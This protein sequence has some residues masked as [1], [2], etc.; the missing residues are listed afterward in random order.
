MEIL[1][2]FLEDLKR[3]GEKQLKIQASNIL[4]IIK[5]QQQN[6]AYQPKKIKLNNIEYL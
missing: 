1:F 4:Q 3:N 5:N 6:T 2:P